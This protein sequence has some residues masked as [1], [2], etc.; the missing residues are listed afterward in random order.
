M[1]SRTRDRRISP[2]TF[3][4]A[5]RLAVESQ[6]YMLFTEVVIGEKISTAACVPILKGSDRE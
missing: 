5:I 3:S 2:A 1:E 4:W 6:L